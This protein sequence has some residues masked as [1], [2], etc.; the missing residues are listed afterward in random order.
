[1]DNEQGQSG[2]CAPSAVVL[3]LLPQRLRLRRPRLVRRVR[4]PLRIILRATPQKTDNLDIASCC[5]LRTSQQ[6]EIKFKWSCSFCRL[7]GIDERW[8]GD[9][10]SHYSEASS[11]SMRRSE[12]ARSLRTRQQ[13]AKRH[14]SKSSTRAASYQRQAR[15][16]D[17]GFKIQKVAAAY[18]TRT[19]RVGGRRRRRRGAVPRR[20][21]RRVRV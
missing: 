8:Q 7:F 4:I 10:G 18:R 1:M 5:H 16:K 12:L 11:V 6:F 9:R 19:A 14:S 21:R 3:R 13:V 17:N 20:I 15:A 2:F